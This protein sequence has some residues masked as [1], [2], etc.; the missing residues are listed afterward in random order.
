MNRKSLLLMSIVCALLLIAVVPAMAQSA[1]AT[2]VPS[3][4]ALTASTQFFATA[5]FRLNVRSGPGVAYTVI[6]Q[7]KAGD[8]VDITGRG[9]K[10]SWVRVNFNGQEGWASFG[11]VEIKG[12]IDTAPEADAGS[13]A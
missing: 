11:L 12:D 10:N 8:S 2:P 13:S 5:N 7:L 1:T 9:P 6:G 4:P 3:T